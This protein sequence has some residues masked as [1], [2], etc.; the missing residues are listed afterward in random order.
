MYLPEGDGPFPAL[1]A[2]APHQKDLLY[3]PAVS[4]FRYI[5]TSPIEPTC[6]LFPKGSRIRPEIANGDSPVA[7]GLF[8]HYYGHQ[9]GRGLIHHDADRPSHLILPIIR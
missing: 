9:V 7:D 1:Y 5:R 6:Y 2:V 8:H 4:T 3:L